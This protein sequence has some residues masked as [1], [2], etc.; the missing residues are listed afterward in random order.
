MFILFILVQQHWWWRISEKF[1]LNKINIY[2]L[3]FYLYLYDKIIRCCIWKLSTNQCSKSQ[4]QEESDTTIVLYAL[5]IT[6][7]D[8]FSELM[9]MCPDTY[10]FLFL[11]H[12]SEIKSSSGFS[13]QLSMSTSY[14]WHMKIWLQML[15]SEHSLLFMP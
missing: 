10:V 11:L 5:D 7:R 12:C 13:R 14:R 8:P 2:R 9:V 15:F 3:C 6:K 4:L 1:L